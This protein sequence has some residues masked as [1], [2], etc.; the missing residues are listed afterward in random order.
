[1]IK[2]G[3]SRK[4][5]FMWNFSGTPWGGTCDR[6]GQTISFISSPFHVFHVPIYIKSIYS[7]YKKRL[8][9]YG[10]LLLHMKMCNYYLFPSFSFNDTRLATKWLEIHDLELSI[11]QIS[12][13]IKNFVSIIVFGSFCSSLVTWHL[14]FHSLP[15]EKILISSFVV[16]VFLF[17]IPF[18]STSMT[19]AIQFDIQQMTI[20][21]QT[22][23]P[24]MS[25]SFC[26]LENIIVITPSKKKW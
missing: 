16:L 9:K 7:N 8:C 14:L 26:S 10:I 23:F 22:I 20:K 13:C 5:I 18:W 19:L 21:P 24:V 17:R 12:I 11:S 1:M 6:P 4:L 3:S 15:W 25:I 2:G